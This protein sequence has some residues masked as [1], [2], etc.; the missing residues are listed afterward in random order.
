M[1]FLPSLRVTRTPLFL[2]DSTVKSTQ[3]MH[4]LVESVSLCHQM[5]RS[6]SANLRRQVGRGDGREG[7]CWEDVW[8]GEAE[9][10][11]LGP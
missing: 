7:C 2:Q 9:S 10:P 1:R 11:T 8:A 6:R 3:E 5:F 4:S